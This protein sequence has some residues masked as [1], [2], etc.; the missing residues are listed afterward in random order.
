MKKKSEKNKDNEF[1]GYPVYPASEDIYSAEK[2][3][4]DIDPESKEK[5]TPVENINGLNEL[6]FSDDVTGSDLDVPGSSDDDAMEDIG[7]EDE[8]NNLYSLGG[9]NHDS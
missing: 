8:E 1:P 5:K 6:D 9:D 2:E 4:I 7:S 3:E